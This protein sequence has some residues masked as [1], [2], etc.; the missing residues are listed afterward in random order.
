MQKQHMAKRNPITR[1][2]KA[3]HDKIIPEKDQDAA[4]KVFSRAKELGYNP[5]VDL[6]EGMR[7]SIE[8][9]RKKETK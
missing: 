4:E 3:I 1:S 9:I 7:R 5:K 6:K 8:W 2:I